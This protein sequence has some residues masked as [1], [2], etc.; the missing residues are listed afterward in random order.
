MLKKNILL[1]SFILLILSGCNND[2]VPMYFRSLQPSG[3]SIFNGNIKE[4]IINSLPKQMYIGSKDFKIDSTYSD[5]EADAEFEKYLYRL[6]LKGRDYHLMMIAS[7]MVPLSEGADFG[8]EIVRNKKYVNLNIHFDENR[9][10]NERFE[11]DD[12]YPDSIFNAM[13]I[14]F[15]KE[16]IICFNKKNDNGYYHIAEIWETDRS[17][18]GINIYEKPFFVGKPRRSPGLF[19][20]ENLNSPIES[21]DKFLGN[22]TKSYNLE[23]IDFNDSLKTYSADPDYISFRYGLRQESY[24]FNNKLSFA[25][26]VY[27]ASVERMESDSLRYEPFIRYMDSFMD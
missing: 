3:G 17:D 8:V 4:R 22:M 12:L 19:T 6:G 10:I 9:K 18:G 14:A 20:E 24:D 27:G 16:N 15:S 13:G 21:F 25:N 26:R 23:I 7:L 11:M 2:D 5:K 1:I